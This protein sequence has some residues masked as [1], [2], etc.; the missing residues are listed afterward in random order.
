MTEDPRNENTK[1]FG[2]EE[3]HQEEKENLKPTIARHAQ[4]SSAFNKA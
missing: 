1:R 3:Y 4:N 2:D